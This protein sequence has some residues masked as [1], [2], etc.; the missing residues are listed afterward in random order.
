[1]SLLRKPELNTRWKKLLL[2][3]VSLLLLVPCAAAATYAMRFDMETNAQDPA[4]Q[5]K[6]RTEKEKREMK[7]RS[8]EGE[9][10]KWRVADPRMR[11]EMVRKEDRLGPLQVSIARHGD[12]AMRFRL[13]HQHALALLKPLRKIF[14]LTAQVE[15]DVQRDLVVATASRV[16]FAPQ[17]ANQLREP[18]FNRHVNVF[19]LRRKFKS[20]PIQLGLDCFEGPHD[21]PSLARLQD[22]RLLQ[23]L[24]VGDAALD[25]LR[26][27]PAIDGHRSGEGFDETVRRFPKST[28]PGLS[29]R[30]TV[31]SPPLGH[32]DDAFLR[33]AR[34][35]NRSA[36]RRIKPSASFWL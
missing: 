25:V 32:Q 30:K 9:E 8:A 17:G 22:P 5:E 24:A 7:A 13:G 4:T 12:R 14:Q 20:A 27:Q 1:M 2:V 10:I 34:I 28:T 33:C 15:P 11:E 23:G 29:I 31:S 36:F 18:P 19:V 3:A 21:R 16:Q 26:V 6:E 35:F